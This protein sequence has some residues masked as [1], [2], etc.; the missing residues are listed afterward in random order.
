M[1]IA[2]TENVCEAMTPMTLAAGKCLH[3]AEK[4]DGATRYC[5]P[6]VL[7]GLVPTSLPMPDQGPTYLTTKAKDWGNVAIC[8]E[9]SRRSTH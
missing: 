5:Q 9:N 1:G 4:K 6:F 3:G 8:S 7:P 2:G